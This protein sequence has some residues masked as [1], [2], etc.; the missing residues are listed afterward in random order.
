MYFSVLIDKLLIA[1]PSYHN[2]VQYDDHLI[3]KVKEKAGHSSVV[4]STDHNTKMVLKF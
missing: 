3:N 2:L 1:T 4:K